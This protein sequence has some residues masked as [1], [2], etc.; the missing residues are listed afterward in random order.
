MGDPRVRLRVILTT[1]SGVASI[2]PAFADEP[3][4]AAFWWVV[5]L[6]LAG[7]ISLS[8]AAMSVQ[9]WEQVSI[10]RLLC[11]FRT[12]VNTQIGRS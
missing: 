12:N 10:P 3:I 1:V 2:G 4:F 8:I 5:A 11:A 9:L 7:G 6:C